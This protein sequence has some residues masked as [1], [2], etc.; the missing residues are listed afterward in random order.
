MLPE[1]DGTIAITGATL[2]LRTW[3]SSAVTNSATFLTCWTRVED[4]TL[5]E[6]VVHVTVAE[7]NEYSGEMRRFIRWQQ[8]SSWNH[9]RFTISKTL[10]TF[11]MDCSIAP[12]M[13]W[14]VNCP[15]PKQLVKANGIARKREALDADASAILLLG[16]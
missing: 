9:D 3:I 16:P 11:M 8:L 15:S 5:S 4:F 14:A 13:H 7:S 2:K 1:M 6:Y 12:K 10:A